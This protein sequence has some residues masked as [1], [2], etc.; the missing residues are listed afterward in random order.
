MLL[1]NRDKL[2]VGGKK[3]KQNEICIGGFF[4]E[5]CLLLVICVKLIVSGQILSIMLRKKNN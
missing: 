1:K 5:C 4:C 2:V 3:T